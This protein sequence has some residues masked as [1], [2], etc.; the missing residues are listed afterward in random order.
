MQPVEIYF[1]Y[2]IQNVFKIIISNTYIF[3]TYPRHYVYLYD[4]HNK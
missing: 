3:S 2:K 1:K 4:F